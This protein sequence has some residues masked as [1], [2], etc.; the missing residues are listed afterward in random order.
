MEFSWWFLVYVFGSLGLFIYGLKVMSEGI[1]RAAGP[2]MRAIL[3]KITGNRFN[4]LLT[5]FVTTSIIQSSSAATVLTVGFVNA[6][7]VNLMQSVGVIIGINIGT[8][9]TGW[10][11]SIL[12]LQFHSAKTILPLVLF[13]LP[14]LFSKNKKANAWGD[15]F[16][17]FLLLVIGLM[18][19][20]EQVPD[21]TLLSEKLE[22]IYRLTAHGYSSLFAIF[23]L[24]ILITLI[25]QSSTATMALTIILCNKGWLPY[26][27]AAA[28][29]LGANIGTTFTAEIAA[30]IGNVEA[31]KTARIHTL[32][33]VLGSIWMFPLL[34]AFTRLVDWFGLYAF[35]DQS[36]YIESNNIPIALSLFHSSFNLLNACIFLAFPLILIKLAERTL[37]GKSSLHTTA[38]KSEHNPQYSNIFNLPELIII[39]IQKNVSDLLIGSRRVVLLIQKIC[40]ETEPDK[41]HAL[42]DQAQALQ[43]TIKDLSSRINIDIENLSA[44]ELTHSTA[45]EINL[46]RVVVKYIELLME[47]FKSIVLLN[48]DRATQNF[49]MDFHQHHFIQQ[50]LG[51]QAEMLRNIHVALFDKAKPNILKSKD[52]HWQEDQILS[53]LGL[54]LS[55]PE[56]P[57]PLPSA[58]NGS[59]HYEQIAALLERN[60]IFLLKITD[61]INTIAR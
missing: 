49:W 53:Q 56:D 57:E 20:K 54:S 45:K 1:Q 61:E 47:N 27:V 42:S 6:G 30:L 22:F 58:K 38:P 25:L 26:E 59:A 35:Y 3:S 32:F 39:Q 34:P 9:I 52:S 33:N 8:T 51:I 24:G 17:G 46:F 36:A 60:R 23:L 55:D 2:Q 15:F 48:E 19:M 13:N 37:S 31:K 7:L 28:M 50:S 14:L 12:D 21:F 44:Q 10:L 5:G 16:M 29:I 4:G 40:K 18:F 41:R 11:I 43:L